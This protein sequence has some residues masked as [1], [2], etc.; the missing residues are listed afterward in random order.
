MGCYR[1]GRWAGGVEGRHSAGGRSGAGCRRQLEAY[2]RLVDLDGDG[3]L[4]LVELIDMLHE[5]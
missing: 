3:Q 1:M 4:D 2:M 5:L